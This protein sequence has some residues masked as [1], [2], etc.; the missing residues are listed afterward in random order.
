M[1]DMSV[2]TVEA[3]IFE[4]FKTRDKILFISFVVPPAISRT[5]IPFILRSKTNEEIESI[6]S[7]ILIKPISRITSNDAKE[8]GYG[9]LSEL[10]KKLYT[11]KLK[12][13]SIMTLVYVRPYIG[14]VE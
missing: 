2:V 10:H 7:S 14:I 3:D 5:N 12:S 11:L 9:S 13:T 8:A 6:A 4:K 1:S